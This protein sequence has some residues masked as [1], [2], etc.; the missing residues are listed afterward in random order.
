MPAASRLLSASS[1][2][3][4]ILLDLKG[5]K[6]LF[7]TNL[8][9][10]P[11]ALALR[12]DGRMVAAASGASVKLFKVSDAS[13]VAEIKGD[14]RL[15]DALTGRQ[16][17]LTFAKSEIEYRKNALQSSVTNRVGIVERK[18]KAGEA[19][20][21]AAKLLLEKQAA[22]TNALALQAKAAQEL[23]E[24]LAV[25]RTAVENYLQA[26]NEGKNATN[27]LAEAKTALDQFPGEAKEKR[28]SAA[29]KLANAKKKTESAAKDLK[30]V[31]ISKSTTDHE[32]EL[33]SEALRKADEAAPGLKTELA[34]A[35]AALTRAESALETAKH[36][37]ADAEKP[38]QMLA[39][40]PDNT[41]LLTGDQT[42][43]LRT[44]SAETGAPCDTVGVLKGVKNAVF[45]EPRKIVAATSSGAAGWDL[46]SRWRLDLVIGTGGSGSPIVDRVN[47]LE[48]TGDGKCL[49][50]G[51]GEPSRDGEIKFW[52][53]ED[54]SLIREFKHLHSDSVFSLDLSPDGKYLASA[55]A[56]RFARITDFVTG[57]VLKNLEGHANHVLGV[58]WARDGRTLVTAGADNQGKTWDFE[59][60]ARR[61]NI[62]G[63]SK[64]VTSVSFMCFGGRAVLTSGDGQIVVVGEDG[65]KVKT[66]RAD[67]DYLY[68]GAVSGDGRTI[69][70]GGS[71]G[72]LRVWTGTDW[73]ITKQFGP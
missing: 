36:R 42:G 55:G 12:P 45:F 61:K 32:L 68:A 21:T 1:N 28:K 30:P 72:V 39:F 34:G 35:E 56:D 52:D 38:V 7:E 22:H 5:G 44:W 41:L 15:A 17:D 59:T 50:S 62:E 54:G 6:T 24:L 14:R 66:L 27:L 53:V 8:G 19:G 33:A 70:A 43:V 13:L 20:A 37:V 10:A 67:D 26:E 2:G 73:N 18:K 48:F 46:A 69:V 58:G 31:E 57:K 71:D 47:A 16:N 9:N 25:A 29:K 49:I 51:G 40:S 65:G 4:V 60:S 63:F 3:R 64:E 23:D 11:A